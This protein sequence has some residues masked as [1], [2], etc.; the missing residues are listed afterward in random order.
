MSVPSEVGASAQNI[1][2]IAVTQYG[3]AYEFTVIYYGSKIGYVVTILNGV[4]FDLSRGCI[5]EL[6]TRR[7]D[8]TTISSSVGITNFSIKEDGLTIILRYRRPQFIPTFNG[9]S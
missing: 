1:M 9:T 7:I 5:W 6:Y 3:S 4:K 2:E 8:G